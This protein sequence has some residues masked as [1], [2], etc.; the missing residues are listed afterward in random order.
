ME[1]GGVFTED[2]PNC[3]SD[4]EISKKLGGTAKK[5]DEW[6]KTITEGYVLERIYDKAITM[7]LPASKLRV[8]QDRMPGRNFLVGE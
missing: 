4:E 5:L 1:E 8:L 3:V 6:L 2:L 7:N